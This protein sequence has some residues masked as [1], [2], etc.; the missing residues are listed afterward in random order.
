[1]KRP[2]IA[3]TFLI[4]L[5]TSCA[6]AVQQT[7]SLPPDLPAP[8]YQF[9]YEPEPQENPIEVVIA[10]I[11]PQYELALSC[12]PSSETFTSLIDEYARS[13]ERD[14]EATLIAKG[15]TLL[16]PF[17]SIDE[18]T[19]GQKEQALLALRPSINV[20]VTC[21]DGQG[22]VYSQIVN[23]DTGRTVSTPG[24]GR[25]ESFLIQDV[26]VVEITGQVTVKSDIS[27]AM[28][29]TLSLE[30]VWQKAVPV[31]DQQRPY[32]YYG[33]SEVDKILDRRGRSL[34]TTLLAGAQYAELERRNYSLPNADE[35]PGV[36]ASILEDMYKS[37]LSQ[38]SAFFDPREMEIVAGEAQRARELKRF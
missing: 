12:T 10:L 33:V 25:G 37:Q 35:R 5:F 21:N 4:I 11:A 14:F 20:T 38:F 6:P 34:T 2:P 17:A 27:L 30:M 18:M 29:E 19:F 15:Y 31:Q 16:G 22:T 28:D 1:M 3:A 9:V 32:S 36:I 24:V 8:N 26:T 23:Q 13:I 7:L